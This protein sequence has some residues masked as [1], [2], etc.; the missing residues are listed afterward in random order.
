MCLFKNIVNGRFYFPHLLDLLDVERGSTNLS[1]HNEKITEIGFRFRFNSKVLSTVFTDASQL[2]GQ[3]V[4]EG[5]VA[6]PIKHEASIS[7]STSPRK[8]CSLGGLAALSL[9][10]RNLRIKCHSSS[11]HNCLQESCFVNCKFSLQSM[12]SHSTDAL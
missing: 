11:F 6:S 12:L 7:A 5:T 10:K 9:K 1:S 4:T 3:K 2:S 8:I